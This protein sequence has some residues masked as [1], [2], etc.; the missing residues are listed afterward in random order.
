[1]TLEE[2]LA[3]EKVMKDERR[4]VVNP[5]RIPKGPPGVRDIQVAAPGGE[6]READGKGQEVKFDPVTRPEHYNRGG[7]E[8]LD[9]IDAAIEGLE[10][11]EAHYTACVIKYMWRWSFKNAPSQDLEKARQ[12]LDR[13]ICSIK[14][15]NAPKEAD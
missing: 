1:M 2:L 5:C 6:A 13:L 9:A 8:C 3:F 12:Y 14:Y 4:S 15:R 7:V 10:G 11:R